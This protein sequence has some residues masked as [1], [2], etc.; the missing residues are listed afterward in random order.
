MKNNR[1]IAVLAM[2][3]GLL[4]APVAS[5]D[6]GMLRFEG[7]VGSAPVGRIN[8]NGTAADPTDD[9]PEVNSIFGVTP[10]GAPWTIAR[11]KAD[12][13]PDGRVSARGEGL[14]LSGGNNFGNRGGPRNVGVS[15]FCRA[16]PVAPATA[17]AQI[18]P[19]NSPPVALDENGDFAVKGMLT[20][21]TGAP[22]PIPCGDTIDNRPVLLIRTVGTTGVFGSWFAGGIIKD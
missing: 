20:D 17:G 18:G 14:L 10:G 12:I 19:F 11:F 1:R 7:A 4:A 9:Y 13:R 22:P 6:S 5:A 3:A 21:A 16:A 8:N 2:A 15:L